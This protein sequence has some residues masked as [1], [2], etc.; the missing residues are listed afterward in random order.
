[1][2]HA[3][4]KRQARGPVGCAVVTI[5]DSRTPETDAS[6]HLIQQQ[7]IAHGH[8]VTH[9]QIV[10]DEPEQL[11]AILS[12]LATNDQCQAIIF[13]GGTGISRRDAT[14]DTLDALLEKRLPG[15]GELFRFLSYQ[16]IGAAAMLSRAVAGTYNGRVVISIPGS[17][18]AARLAMEK[19][20]LPELAHMVWEVNR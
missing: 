9:Y 5:S 14:F 6:G 3:E 18:A 12:V 10:K 7:L 16:E 15:F 8:V 13:N 19:L 20:I 17:P 1:M 2:S 4:H 11:R